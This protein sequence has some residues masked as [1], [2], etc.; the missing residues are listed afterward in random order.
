MIISRTPF[1]M[2]FVGGGTDLPAYYRE[3]GGAVLSTTI[4]KFM[5]ITVS[6]KFDRSIR[7]SYSRTEEVASVDEIQHKVV[8]EA[9][10]HLGFT[11]GLEITSVA[12]IPARGTGLGSSSAFT[13]GLLHALHVHRGRY[14]S[15]EALAEQA[16]EVEIVRCAEPIG[17]QDTYAA[18]FGGLNYIQF[19][20]DDTVTVH[21]IICRRETL[22]ALEAR[23]LVLYTGIQRSASRLLEAQAAGLAGRPDRLRALARMAESAR[24]LRDALRENRL[25]GMGELLH[26]NWLLKRSL[27]AEVATPEIDEWYARARAAGAEGGKILGAGAGGFLMLHA[28]PERHDAIAGALSELRRVRFRM[29]REGSKIIFVH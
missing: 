18:A 22:E 14:V 25:E 20:P 17:K 1:R 23:T 10:K 19:D 5:F 7:V 4:D 8:R 21:P 12:D 2:S 26:E 15:A 11:G 16:C 27:S 6:E 29:T 13:V 28:P 24:E 9:L 3:H